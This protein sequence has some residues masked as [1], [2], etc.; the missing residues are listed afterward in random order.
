[1]SNT[2]PPAAPKP[3]APKT[4]NRRAESTEDDA[5]KPTHT[6]I[7]ANGDA[8]DVGTPGEDDGSKPVKVLFCN[9]I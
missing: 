2:N 6:L 1:M 4:A 8:V 5:P 3:Q 9:E 7:L